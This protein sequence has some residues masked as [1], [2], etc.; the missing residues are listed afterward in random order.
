MG[1]DFRLKTFLTL[2]NGEKITAPEF[3]KQSLKQLRKQNKSVS[4]KVKGSNNWYR[5]I[6]HL[7]RLYRKVANQRLD[8]QW[9]VAT[10]LCRRFDVI[11]TETLNLDGI[12]RLWA[13]KYLTSVSINLFNC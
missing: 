3:L 5:A 7:T 10:D 8:W 6:R 9:K 1:I 11:V 2:S 13:E 4:R 12:K